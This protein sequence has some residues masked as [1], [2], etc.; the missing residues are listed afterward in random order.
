M[1]PRRN[2]LGSR[3][4]TRVD[5]IK[6]SPS[7]NITAL[8]LPLVKR[9]RQ[10]EIAHRLLRYDPQLEQ[11]GFVEPAAGKAMARL[12][13]MGGEL[14][15]NGACALA[16]H[17]RS[18][19]EPVAEGR[20]RLRRAIISPHNLPSLATFLNH[21]GHLV[22][23]SYPQL[24]GYGE[25]RL[26]V[27][28]QLSGAADLHYRIDP[29]CLDQQLGSG[30]EGEDHLLIDGTNPAALQTAQARGFYPVALLPYT[31]DSATTH[32]LGLP[33]KR[34]ALRYSGPP[35]RVD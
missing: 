15:G 11:V 29:A 24:R 1:E 31:E 23:H 35:A 6:T 13:M 19:V 7:G 33:A 18:Q 2:P 20:R 28:A 16:W 25:P 10:V 17:L 22:E 5:F 12:Q 4:A 26:A 27:C 32:L 34:L 21:C 14:C 9:S 30:Q 3:P 8:V